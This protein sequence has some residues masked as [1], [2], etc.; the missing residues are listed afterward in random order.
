MLTF[1]GITTGFHSCCGNILHSHQQYTVVSVYPQ[2]C[3]DLLFS[4]VLFFNVWSS[5]SWFWFCVSLKTNDV[6]YVIMCLLAIFLCLWRNVCSPKTFAHILIRLFENR[7][8]CME[9]TKG[10]TTKK[11]E[12]FLL[13]G[14]WI[15]NKCV[16]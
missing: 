4:V 2:P 1:G 6:K 15:L 7:T 5:I 3:W 8:S 14:K 11:S 12:M 13:K 9:P 16:L 10:L